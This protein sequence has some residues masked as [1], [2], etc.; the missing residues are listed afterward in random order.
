MLRRI[1]RRGSPAFTLIELLVV[2]AIIAILIGLLLPAVQKVR[3]AAARAKSQNN[4][5]QI[6]LA[7]HNCQGVYDK[8]P[9]CH[10]TFPKSGNDFRSV[11]NPTQTDWNGPA[12]MTPAP[13]G[14]IHYFLLPYIEQDAV[15]K[16]Q[17][18]LQT[19]I[20]NNTGSTSW[21]TK[22]ASD[23]ISLSALKIYTAPNDPSI[24]G[25]AIT[26][27][28]S[29]A[30]SYAANW[31]AFG[32]GWDDDWQSGGK[33]RIPATFPD[34]TSNTI[35]FLERYA[36]CG[37]GAAPNDWDHS[38]VH[39]ERGWQ[40]DGAQPGPIAQYNQA[41]ACWNSPS[42]W[43]PAGLSG[44]G[45]GHGGFNGYANIAADYPINIVTG[46]SAYLVAPQSAPPIKTCDPTRLQAYGGSTMQVLMMDGSVRGVSVSVDLATLARALVPN[47]GFPLG[48]D[49]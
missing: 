39:A 44:G 22:D 5:K 1:P 46:T 24:T 6:G 36:I 17:S 47:D 45:T 10:G 27:D 40:E 35:G 12:R 38:W 29:G 21:M 16:K 18:V 37:D 4:L 20:N 48:S 41:T 19:A 31:H 30:A 32:G 23:G 34:G 42:Y 8:L 9:K 3:E 15:Y 11:T 43:I 25:D 26:W 14:T 33:A 7:I 28:R 49:W 13:F 2:I